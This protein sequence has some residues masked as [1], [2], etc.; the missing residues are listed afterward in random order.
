MPFVQF[1]SIELSATFEKVIADA[2]VVGSFESTLPEA[3][4]FTTLAPPPFND[5]VPLTVPNVAEDI[6]RI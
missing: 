3:G 2:C 6:I 4:K 5:I 1:I